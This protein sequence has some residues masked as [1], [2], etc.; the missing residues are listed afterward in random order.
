M[1]AI[2]ARLGVI[3]FFCMAATAALALP[4]P[5]RTATGL[6]EGV[7]SSD[8]AVT[9]FKGIPYAL[10]PVGDR[11]WK[12]PQPPA[13]WSGVRQTTAFGNGCQQDFPKATFPMSEDCLYVNVWTPAENAQEKLPVLVW[14]HGGGLVVGAA[15][16]ALYDGE[17]LARQHVVVV[18]FNYRLGIFGFFAHPE[19][20]KESAQ[21]AAGNYGFLD[22][23]AALEWVQKNVAAFGGD[24]A[25]VTIF[26]QSAGGIS[27][28]SLIASP[29]A[30]GLFRA[31]I[32]QSGGGYS[33]LPVV[34]R[35]EQEKAGV[36]FADSL[37]A[38]SLAG[39]R[40]MS[41]EMLV[42]AAKVKIDLMLDVDGVFFTQTMQESYQS[43]KINAVP[44]MTGSNLDEG[45]H[46]LRNALSVQAYREVAQHRYGA[47]VGSYMALYPAANEV[48]AK[49]SQLHFFA[50]RFAAGSWELADAVSR[51]GSKVYLYSFIHVDQGEYNGEQPSLGLR[52][53]P[54]H[55]AELPYVFGLLEHWK[56]PV[57][58]AD[59]ALEKSVMR[60]WVNFAST[61]DPNGER[62][63]AWTKFADARESSM[64]LEDDLGMKP[65]PRPRQIQ[66]LRQQKQGAW[67]DR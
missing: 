24:P 58:D 16:E 10:P 25:K 28:N 26:G 46:M 35:Q 21:N 18:T 56:A 43:G 5:V 61:L 38:K 11:R 33:L 27:V 42:R 67:N 55:G 12:A 19:L 48:E 23:V 6:V 2:K 1:S 57:P 64:S 50:D 54:D 60:Y 14:I 65:N 8:G 41:A 22:Q 9:A 3:L 59:R 39:L 30:K 44:L 40:A 31:A 7:S 51:A 45:Q 52:L 29:R 47:E 32:S 17:Q 37:Q 63:P 4:M 53:G 15:N 66:F 13:S 49:A 36:K 34:T 20:T 62:L